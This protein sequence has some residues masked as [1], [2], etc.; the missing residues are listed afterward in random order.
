MNWFWFWVLVVSHALV[1]VGG[2]AVGSRHSKRLKALRNEAEEF[3]AKCK[4][5]AAEWKAKFESLKS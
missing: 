5:E 1:L 4:A 2:L 3:S